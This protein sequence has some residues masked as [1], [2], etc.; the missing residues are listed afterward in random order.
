[1]VTTNQRARRKITQQLRR[2]VTGA[3]ILHIRTVSFRLLEDLSRFYRHCT[4]MQLSQGNQSRIIHSIAM[5]PL[6][7]ELLLRSHAYEASSDWNHTRHALNKSQILYAP[8]LTA[9]HGGQRK[10]DPAQIRGPDRYELDSHLWI[11]GWR[12]AKW[13]NAQGLTQCLLFPPQVRTQR[14]LL[15]PPHLCLLPASTYFDRGTKQ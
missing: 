12:V 2:S 1:M 3:R 15:P 11:A 10:N 14:H 9:R 13:R 4:S 8:T 7:Q 6:S 5:L